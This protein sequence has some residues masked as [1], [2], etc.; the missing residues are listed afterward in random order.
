MDG[1]TDFTKRS[2]SLCQR[3]SSETQD[4]ASAILSICP[5]SS[6]VTSV[7]SSGM[8]NP[9]Q[10]VQLV[11]PI[12]RTFRD[13]M[14]KSLSLLVLLSCH[15][16]VEPIKVVSMAI[17]CGP[18]FYRGTKGRIKDF[19]RPGLPG[20]YR[21]KLKPGSQIWGSCA[22]RAQVETFRHLRHPVA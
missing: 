6:S 22:Y 3:P 13:G 18:R 9:A 1:Y 20:A 7:N 21:N 8:Q 12:N 16:S 11:V 5:R 10:F 17:P 14:L 15:E 4:V 2:P 19:F